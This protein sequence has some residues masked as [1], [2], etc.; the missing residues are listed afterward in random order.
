[1]KAKHRTLLFLCFLAVAS[2]TVWLA[3]SSSD[4]AGSYSPSTYS[5]R[6]GGCK[7]IYELFRE[8]RLPVSRMGSPYSRL[9]SRAGTLVVVDPH[10]AR[11]GPREVKNLNQWIDRGNRLI[12]FSGGPRYLPPPPS[13]VGSPT[14]PNDLHRAG[15]YSLAEKLGL[16]RSCSPDESRI[17][18]NVASLG[19]YG[20]EKISVSRA[21]R[22]KEP[23]S[24]WK[25]VAQD[26][27]GPVVVRRTM[28][29]G[30]IVAVSDATLLSNRDGDREQNV[31]FVLALVLEKER[32][33]EI[34]FDEYHHGHAL[35]ESFWSFAGSSVFSW[36]LLQILIG[37]ALF[38]YG[39]RAAQSGRFRSLEPPVGR[40]SLEYVESMAHIFESCKAGRLAL[41]ALLHRFLALVSR[42]AGVSLKRLEL[43]RSKQLDLKIPG[44]WDVV[45]ECRKAIRSDSTEREVLSMARKLT[46]MQAEL[47][48]RPRAISRA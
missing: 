38:F 33:R 32:P 30:E 9:E 41:E 25:T 46:R 2:L 17:T 21:T 43:A 4:K 36:I 10:E 12:V 15:A 24:E 1:M 39:R 18:V 28:G 42:R 29:K 47:K 6:P 26:N 31:R 20:V 16:K 23:S 22:W 14:K 8:L 11:L 35:A 5:T 13:F 27:A 7:A 37:C 40:S 48:G 34:M 19:L 44:S 3:G 45:E